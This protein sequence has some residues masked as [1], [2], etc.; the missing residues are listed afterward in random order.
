M[1][2]DPT[3]WNPAELPLRLSGALCGPARQNPRD[4]S[5]GIQQSS[6][7]PGVMRMVANVA[8]RVSFN[9]SGTLLG[10]LADELAA[11]ANKP[12][13]QPSHGKSKSRSA[14]IESAAKADTSEAERTVVIGDGAPWIEN[15]AQE[16]FPKAIQIVDRFHV[17]QQL[18][19]MAKARHPGKPSQAKLC[20]EQRHDQLDDGKLA[21]LH[22]QYIRLRLRAVPPLFR[23]P[24]NSSPHLL[25][26]DSVL[27]QA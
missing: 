7:S 10:E 8:A 24:P 18:D 2:T 4:G 11:P 6:L 16:L 14:A 27:H 25:N 22:P 23:C 26:G 3:F 9:E 19:D 17:K 5:L 13:S 1:Q 21:A 20:A 15:I 12:M